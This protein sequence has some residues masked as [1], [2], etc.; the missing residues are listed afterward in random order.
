MRHEI[1]SYFEPDMAWLGEINR[2]LL[3]LERE[4]CVFP[5]QHTHL[6]CALWRGREGRAG[7]TLTLSVGDRELCSRAE[8]SSPVAATRRAFKE[9]RS[10]IAKYAI[11]IQ[12]Q[13]FG[14]HGN[15]NRRALNRLSGTGPQLTRPSITHNRLAAAH[16]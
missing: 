3:R 6:H 12:G 11:E 4:V 16:N 2:R 8:D 14:L 7:M 13:D 10:Q 5:P 9:L 1:E 15:H